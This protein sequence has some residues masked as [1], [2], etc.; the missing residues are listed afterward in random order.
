MGHGF[1][2]IKDGCMHKCDGLQLSRALQFE[3]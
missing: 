2:L 3:K 1:G